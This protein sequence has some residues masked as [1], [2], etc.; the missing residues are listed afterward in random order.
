MSQHKNCMSNKLHGNLKINGSPYHGCLWVQSQ[1]F[2]K[3]KNYEWG[4]SFKQRMQSNQNGIILS[5]RTSNDTQK[6]Y[7]KIISYIIKKETCTPNPNIFDESKSRSGV[8]WAGFRADAY[9]YN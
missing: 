2:Q 6:F 9:N 8:W 5:C 1:R 7:E 4:D 3:A